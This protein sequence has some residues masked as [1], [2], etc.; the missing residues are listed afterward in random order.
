MLDTGK[1][2]T[3]DIFSHTVAN[4]PWIAHEWLSEVFMAFCYKLGGLPAVTLVFIV[5]ASFSMTLLFKASQRLSN[6]WSAFFAVTIAVALS[7]SHLLARPH[8]FS[9]LFGSLFLYLLINQDRKLWILPFLTAIWSNLHGGVL[10]GL[11][12]QGAFL[13]GQFLDA[14]SE[15]SITDWKYHWPRVRQPLYILILSL[16]ALGC[17]PFGY[18]LL[19]FPFQVSAEVFSQNITE[20]KAPDLQEM[21]YVRVWLMMLAALLVSQGR[22]IP[23]AWRLLLIVLLYQ[24]LGH[25]RHLS[26]AAMFLAPW[27]AMSIRESFRKNNVQNV[28]SDEVALSTYSG[29]LLIAISFI[30]LCSV[31]ISRP[32]W[33]QNFTAKSITLPEKFTQ[34]AI[35]YLEENG[36]P[37]KRLLNDY[38]WGGFLLFALETPPKVFID[39][40]ADMYG[41][42]VFSDYG[43]LSSL[44][45]DT[46]QLLT[47]YKIDWILFPK[48]SL[49]VRYIN[50]KPEW[51]QVY[52]DDKISILSLKK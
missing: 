32:V 27:T 31:S 34:G 36:Y 41:E 30:L 52:R 1:I 16:L 24:A 29:P 18:S 23:W 39:G 40:R 46:E 10:I 12:L 20:W 8:I 51:E 49:L 43:K 6:E 47:E 33:W 28:K 37:G 35:S 22:R 9:W 38:S 13:S 42:K 5:M 45:A 11:V 21:W 2:L 26:V 3:H 17:N 15:K 44:H 25:I 48:D 14:C 19:W 50:T 4:K 7:Q